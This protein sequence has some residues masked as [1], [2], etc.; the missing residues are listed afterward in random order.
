MIFK[1]YNSYQT[2]KFVCLK[3]NWWIKKLSC[4]SYKKKNQVIVS[5]GIKKI[6]NLRIYEDCNE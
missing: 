6:Q 2:P 5:C 4:C 1:I 3:K